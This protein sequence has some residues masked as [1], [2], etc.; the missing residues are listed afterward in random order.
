MEPAQIQLFRQTMR[1][2]QPRLMD[3]IRILDDLKQD[4]ASIR[5]VT[6]SIDDTLRSVLSTF[7]GTE[8]LK[9]VTDFF[10]SQLPLFHAFRSDILPRITENYQKLPESFQKFALNKANEI[11]LDIVGDPP[12]L[13]L[14]KK[15]NSL[16]NPFS[17][18]QGDTIDVEEFLNEFFKLYP[19][20]I[21][22]ESK[23][24]NDFRDKTTQYATIYY[25]LQ[26]LLDLD[27]YYDMLKDG[28]P[29]S[30]D[31]CPECFH[32][33]A[34]ECQKKNARPQNGGK[35]NIMPLVKTQKGPNKF[36]WGLVKI[37]TQPL[38]H[39]TEEKV[40]KPKHIGT[41]S[42]SG[43]NLSAHMA[44]Q[45]HA[46]SKKQSQSD[47]GEPK[48]RNG[49]H[50][51]SEKMGI[52]CSNSKKSEIISHYD[53]LVSKLKKDKKLVHDRS[54]ISESLYEQKCAF[55]KQ[56]IQILR[57]NLDIVQKQKQEMEQLYED[58]ISELMKQIEFLKKENSE[59]KAKTNQDNHPPPIQ[60][61]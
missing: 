4:S 41:L 51:E 32:S 16:E 53:Q 22:T 46:L 12:F 42:L 40:G 24:L 5:G 57:E 19:S 59:L 36:N 52:I 43:L 44:N 23:E 9:A 10:A 1:S 21:T 49:R 31:Q 6:N 2:L 61:E 54:A 56:E 11:E 15:L 3:L 27:T 37:E 34:K 35:K 45:D 50:H 25:I 60:P 33:W 48:S 18:L 30:C 17:D 7:D 39:E 55:H 20:L 47:D 8:K 13:E 28:K 29:P 58:H 26:Q 14:M 38:L